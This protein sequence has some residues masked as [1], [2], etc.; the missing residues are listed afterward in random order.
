MRYSPTRKRLAW[1][2][3]GIA[4][5]A[6]LLGLTARW[7][8][9]KRRRRHARHVVV[10]LDGS[11]G[12]AG[13]VGPSAAIAV[14]GTSAAAWRGTWVAALVFVVA[15]ALATGALAY[16]DQR[17]ER[18]VQTATGGASDRAIPLILANGCAACHTI[19]GVPRAQG[20]VGPRLD[21]TLSSRV[22]LAGVLPNDRQTMIRWLRASREM[23][24]HTAMPS[25]GISEQDARDIAAY[26]YALR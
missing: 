13:E 2:A 4:L 10:P 15:A 14:A 12:P 24:P 1:L 17:A 5:L 21:A 18:L 6:L 3:G 22:Y 7:A 9:R 25:T 23:V 19:P 26:L 16:R 11:Q 8:P 20:Q